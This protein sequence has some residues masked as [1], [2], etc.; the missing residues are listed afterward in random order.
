MKKIYVAMIVLSSVL[1]LSSCWKNTEKN[2]NYE[3]NMAV[4]VSQEEV[5]SNAWNEEMMEEQQVLENAEMVKDYPMEKMEDNM[6]EGNLEEEMNDEMKKQNSQDEM[7]NK[8]EE[9]SVE[10]IEENMESQETMMNQEENSKESYSEENSMNEEMSEEDKMNMKEEGDN[11]YWY[12]QYSEDK[13]SSSNTNILFFHANWCPS[14]KVLDDNLTKS[15]IPKN[16]NILKIDYDSSSDLRKKYWIVIQHSFV[17][18]DEN[19]NMIKKWVGWNNLE[20]I[21]SE[22]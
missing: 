12:N 5:D 2:E 9:V 10:K 20:D 6:M 1:I 21:V 4:E 7:S 3:E 16:I 22:I 17:Q 11:M 13:L 19:W 8:Q 14:C 18:V 15:E